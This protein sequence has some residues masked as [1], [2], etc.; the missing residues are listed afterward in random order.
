MAA[1]QD[2]GRENAQI[3]LF[4]LAKPVGEGRAGI[5]AILVLDNGTEVPFELKTTTNG[6]VTTVRDFGFAHIEKWKNKH[7]LISK[8]SK[9]GTQMEYAIYGSPQAM[10]TWIE[11][12]EAYITPD[13]ELAKIAPDQLVLNHLY[14]VIE[15]KKIYT[16]SDAQK[17]HKKQF[18]V[19]KYKELMDVKDGYTPNLMLEILK[20]RCKYLIERGSTLNNPHIPA[21]YF[22]GWERITEN[23]SDRLKVMVTQSLN[24]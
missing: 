6:S 21:S 1:I 20:E 9:D 4:G 13:F 8:Y 3:E 2:D 14:K 17:L 15:K 11:E 18:K 24:T 23:H 16:L 10:S 12:K 5:D 22:E 7:W 19:S